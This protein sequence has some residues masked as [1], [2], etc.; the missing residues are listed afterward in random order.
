MTVR[1]VLLDADDV[2]QQG[3]ASFRADLAEALGDHALSW[4]R[5]TFHPD[6]D[7]LTG[8]LEVVPLLARQLAATG[9]SADAQALYDRAWLDI[10]PY[11]P[12]LDLVAGWRAT[13]LTVHLATNQDAG[14]TAYMKTALGYDALLDGAYYS[15]DLG[16]AKPAA[17]YFHAI[18]DDLGSPPDEVVFVDDLATN[19]DGA[20]E[21]G[22]RV[23][24]WEIGDGLPVLLERL[25]EAGLS[26]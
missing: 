24:H 8:R 9:H 2:L 23:V 5:E 11:P 3:T 26:A 22:L 16:V 15:S 14:R 20:R 18:L 12:V 13:G 6:G 21:V 19:V 7:V 25:A 4:L 17:A 1:H 10:T